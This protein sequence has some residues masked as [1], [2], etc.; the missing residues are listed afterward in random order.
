MLIQTERR[1]NHSLK[2]VSRIMSDMKMLIMASQIRKPLFL[3]FYSLTHF[4][5]K[6]Q[7]PPDPLSLLYCSRNYCTAIRLIRYLL[8]VNA[9]LSNSMFASNLFIFSFIASDV[10]LRCTSSFKLARQ[11]SMLDVSCIRNFIPY[12]KTSTFSFAIL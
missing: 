7:R 10:I 5:L 2:H 12:K 8:D 9:M 3:K 4:F 1:K 11:I 6:M